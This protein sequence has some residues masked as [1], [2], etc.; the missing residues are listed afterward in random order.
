MCT[1]APLCLWGR[2][3]GVRGAVTGFSANFQSCVIKA[4]V[5]LCFLAVIIVVGVVVCVAV[6]L[7]VSDNVSVNRR[8]VC[9]SDHECN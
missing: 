5:L 9:V 6:V 7:V 2:G 3:L 8:Y 1:I 4:N